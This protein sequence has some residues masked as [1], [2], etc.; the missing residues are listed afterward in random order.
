MQIANRGLSD[1]FSRKKILLRVHHSVA[2]GQRNKSWA[3]P[4]FIYEGTVSF[5]TA[6]LVHPNLKVQPRLLCTLDPYIWHFPCSLISI[7]QKTL[8]SQHVQN[9]VHDIIPKNSP[10]SESLFQRIETTL[11]QGTI[12]KTLS[13]HSLTHCFTPRWLPT[14]FRIK[15][16][17]CNTVYRVL[18][19]SQPNPM[20]CSSLSHALFCT[21]LVPFQTL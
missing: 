17:V 2:N 3:P 11:I 5:S 19:P 7:S 12:Q 9:G 15:K 4:P 6:P 16:I 14:A 21:T 13:H 10:Y 8:Q 20:P 1:L 18:I